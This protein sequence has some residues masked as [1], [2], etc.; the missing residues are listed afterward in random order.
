MAAFASGDY[1]QSREILE[2]LLKEN[3]ADNAVRKNLAVAYVTLGDKAAAR[4]ILT[5]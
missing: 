2:A 4:K 3:P 1:E 5:G